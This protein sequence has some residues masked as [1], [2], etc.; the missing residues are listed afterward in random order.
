MRDQNYIP[1]PARRPDGRGVVRLN[2]TDHYLGQ[3]GDW[4]KSQRK[5]PPAVI[6]L[7]YEARITPL[8]P[9][10]VSARAH[11]ALSFSVIVTLIALTVFGY[12]KGR[13]TGAIPMRSAF[14]TALVGG[15]AATAAF[16]LAKLIS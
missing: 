15:L 14:Q 11:T 9:Y 8:A 7:A 1:K 3:A 13:F 5:K 10:I 6:Q 4:P 2:G 16:V 12:I